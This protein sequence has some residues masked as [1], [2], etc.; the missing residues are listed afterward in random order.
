MTI[1]LYSMMLG[2]RTTSIPRIQDMS[3]IGRFKPLINEKVRA[4][5]DKIWGVI[6]I[7]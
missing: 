3:S 2:K 1:A 7:Y 5:K 4:I 6:K